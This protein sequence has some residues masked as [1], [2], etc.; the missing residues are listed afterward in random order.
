MD[1]RRHLGSS[2]AFEAAALV[3]LNGK[4]CIIRNNMSITL[5]DVSNTPTVIEINS[6][7]MW[8]IFARKGQH[9][10][11]ETQH[12]CCLKEPEA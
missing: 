8:D 7:H 4:I 12:L 10:N 2:R 5:V 9:R 11:S 3:S 6:A 1:S